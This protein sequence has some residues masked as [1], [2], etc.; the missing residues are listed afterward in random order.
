MNGNSTFL[1]K[2]FNREVCNK[3]NIK[4]NNY[5]YNYDKIFKNFRKKD[6]I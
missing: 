5:N 2:L 6:I 4:F 1:S 3:S